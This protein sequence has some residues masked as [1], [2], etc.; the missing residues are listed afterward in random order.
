MHWRR[1]WLVSMLWATLI[2]KPFAN[3]SPLLTENIQASDD[4][5][6]LSDWILAEIGTQEAARPDPHNRLLCLIIAR[7]LIASLS[8]DHQ[9]A[10][11]QK[12]LEICDE[13]LD[14]TAMEK[15]D[16]GAPANDVVCVLHV[17]GSIYH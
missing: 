5:T 2:L 12:V 14:Q 16:E 7:R 11:S 13:R 1:N 15:A 4:F 10:F 3:H 9:I 8:G 17:N 6:A